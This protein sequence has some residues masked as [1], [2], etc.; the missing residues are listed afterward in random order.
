M[1]AARRYLVKAVAIAF[2]LLLVIWGRV[3]ML[4]RSH[5]NEAERYYAESNYKLALREY[6]T[7]L[8]FFTPFSPYRARAVSRLWQMG[9]MFEAADKPDWAVIAYSSVRSSFYA[10]RGLYT[11]GRDWIKKCDA[12]LAS[13]N[14]K[15]LL[16]DGVLSPDDAPREKDRLLFVLTEDREPDVFWSLI[17]GVAFF[18]WVGSA[19]FVFFSGFDP[20]GK[21]R[22]RHMLIG[23]L[24]F[25]IT[26]GLW[27]L[28]LLSA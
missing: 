18:G 24:A 4:Q 16:R 17:V 9:E 3:L 28:A 21:M 15:L 8:H 26:F 10:A 13:L 1:R 12:K 27:T 14:V 20:A 23:V 22:G 11:P 5:F 2:I 7:A 6:D 25:I 19:L